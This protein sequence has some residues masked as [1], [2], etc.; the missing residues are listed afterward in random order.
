[1]MMALIKRMTFDF[2]TLTACDKCIQMK[3]MIVHFYDKTINSR[4]SSVLAQL[5]Q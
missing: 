1:M 3:E 2:P 5:F 4:V